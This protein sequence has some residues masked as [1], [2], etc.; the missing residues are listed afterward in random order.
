MLPRLLFTPLA[1]AATARSL[2]VAPWHEAAGTRRSAQRTDLIIIGGGTGG[3]AAALAACERGLSVVLTEETAWIGGQLT[4]QAVP[5]DE[6]AW[7]ESIGGTATYRALRAAVRDHY[8][9][10]PALRPAARANPR[11]NPGNGWVSRLCAEPR[12]WHDALRLA[13]APH[14]AA[15]RLTIRTHTRAVA[16]DV[17]GDVVRAVHVRH[18]D[19]RDTVFEAPFVVDA[20]ELGELLPLCNVEHV[21]GAESQAMTGEP[22]A[23]S[24]PQPDNQQSFTVVFGME[25]RAGEEHT[26]D[27]PAT[28][29]TWRDA[30][31]LQHGTRW[32]Q[33]SFDE[34]ANARIGFDPIARTGYWSYRRVIDHTLFAPGT[35]ASDVT[36]VNWWQNDYSGGP[37]VGGD[38]AT[39]LAAARELSRSLLYWLQ[40]EMP[41]P[42]GGIGYPGLRLRPDVVGTTDGLAMTPYIRESRRIVARTTVREQDVLKALLPPDTVTTA[43]TDSVGIGHYALDLHR[44]TRGD[45]G[46]YGETVPFQIPLG[47]LIPVRVRNLLPACKNFGVTHRTNGCYRLH[48]IEWNVGEA[49]GHLVAEALATQRPPSAIAERAERT[50]DL[51]RTLERAGVRLAWPVPLPTA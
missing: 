35:H 47:A 36:L 40:T 48:P 41:R 26:I 11:L 17:Q 13:L 22:G 1:F 31:L 33:L 3:C 4:A 25:H 42:D 44:T 10:D 9:N 21:T 19:G 23:P 16:A 28:Y 30:R 6:N 34:P 39:H 18:A 7:I 27:R 50:R 8:R 38:A 49:V 46:A 15:G 51:Q 24:E 43:F 2:G 14:V 29:A 12:V 20:T 5:P 45:E 37:L 32:R